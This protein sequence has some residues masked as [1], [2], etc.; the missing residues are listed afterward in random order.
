M[1][2]QDYICPLCSSTED[3]SSN[4][5]F[6]ECPFAFQCWIWINLQPDPSIDPFQNLQS[7]KNQL[8]APFF[9]E[10]IILMC[11]VIWKARNDAIFR[12]SAP[13]IQNLK[14]DFRVELQLLMLRAKRSYSPR[15]DQWITSLG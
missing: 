10:I 11:W 15:F 2:L 4:H 9:M 3:E 13:N 8:Q 7:F 6:L 14:M 12:Q 5:L 1:L